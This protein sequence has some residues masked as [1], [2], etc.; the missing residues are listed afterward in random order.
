MPLDYFSPTAFNTLQPELRTR[1]SNGKIGLPLDIHDAFTR[2]PNEMLD[3]MQLM[4]KFGKEILQQYRLED[5]D[6]NEVE[7]WLDDDEMGD[8]SDDELEDDQLVNEKRSE[9]ALHLSMEDIQE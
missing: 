3:D 4:N 5:L 9:L 1:V 2:N 7:E 8:I 6:D